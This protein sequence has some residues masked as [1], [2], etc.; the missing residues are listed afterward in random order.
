[1]GVKEDRRM[2]K[3]GEGEISLNA[4]RVALNLTCASDV[5]LMDPW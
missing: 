1:M 3:R 4:G 5:M 2:I